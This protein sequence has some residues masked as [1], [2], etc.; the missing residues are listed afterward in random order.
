LGCEEEE[1]EV[2]LTECG[3]VRDD[4]GGLSS[5][6][7][8]IGGLAPETLPGRRVGDLC[9]A[10]FTA[11]ILGAHGLFERQQRVQDIVYSE[12][13]GIGICC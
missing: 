13:V 2:G 11:A 5:C 6:A 3:G 1:Q 10:V 7:L 8:G 9:N 4:C 12:N